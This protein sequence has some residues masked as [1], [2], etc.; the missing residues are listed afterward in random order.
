MTDTRAEMKLKLRRRAEF[1]LKQQL[2]RIDW[3]EDAL[4]RGL[5]SAE[6]RAAFKEKQRREREKW[7]A[8][9]AGH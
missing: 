5:L 1:V 7:L 6:S 3:E 4:E 2:E 9:L 8:R